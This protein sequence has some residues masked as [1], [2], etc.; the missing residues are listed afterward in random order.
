MLRFKIAQIKSASLLGPEELKLEIAA[1][2]V[3]AL[4]DLVILSG[5]A[6][7]VLTETMVGTDTE[8]LQA[9]AGVQILQPYLRRSYVPNFFCLPKHEIKITGIIPFLIVNRGY[10]QKKPI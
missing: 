9:F 10:I 4:L 8:V 2:C 6:A 7:K 5:M 1:Y 3:D